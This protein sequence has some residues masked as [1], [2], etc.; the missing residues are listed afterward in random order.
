MT[1]MRNILVH[2]YLGGGDLET[3]WI[4]VEKHLPELEQALSRL[5]LDIQA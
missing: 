5:M 4:V 1:G 3:L 2:D